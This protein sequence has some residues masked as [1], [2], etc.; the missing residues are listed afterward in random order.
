MCRFSNID[1][2]LRN[3][4]NN[5]FGEENSNYKHVS[6]DAWLPNHKIYYQILLRF[7]AKQLFTNVNVPLFQNVSPEHVD[8]RNL[9]RIMYMLD[10][11]LIYHSISKLTLWASF[12][13]A[14]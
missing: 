7:T 14:V 11:Y 10:I 3:W 8:K 4:Y 2:V 9:F 1:I 13:S 12:V 6:T 5:I